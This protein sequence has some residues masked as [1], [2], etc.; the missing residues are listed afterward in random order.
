MTKDK[1]PNKINRHYHLNCKKCGSLFWSPDAW[2]E[3]C[4]K[5][6]YQLY[7]RLILPNEQDE[8]LNNSEK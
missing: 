7:D 2:K 1:K 3:Y 4:P 8:L 6:S 5:C